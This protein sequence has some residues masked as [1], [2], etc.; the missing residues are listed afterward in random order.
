MGGNEHLDGLR[1]EEWIVD[2]R[3]CAPDSLRDETL[4]RALFT[5]AVAALGLHPVGDAVFHRFPGEGGITGFVVLSESHLS[6]HTYPESGYAAF[7][8]YSC[9]PHVRWDW[10]GEL[11]RALGATG[12]QVRRVQRPGESS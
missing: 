9:R 5:R 7:N 8:L 1:G 2:A 12:V 4:L 6:C 11:G 3:G 10:E